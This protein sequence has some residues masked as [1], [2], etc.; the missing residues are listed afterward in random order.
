MFDPRS[1]EALVGRRPRL[2]LPRRAL[3]TAGDDRLVEQVRSGSNS[4]FEEIYDRHHR[5]IL[6]FCRHMLGSREEAEDAVQHTFIAA[7]QSLI[8]DDRQ[9]ALKAWL[10]TV[11]RNRCLSLLRAR[12]EHD[13]IDGAETVVP[14]TAGLSDEVEQREDLRTLLVD[15][16]RLPEDQRA[17]LVLAELEAH[18]HDEIAVILDVR[19]AKVK[20]LVFQAREGLMSRRLARE[21]DCHDIRE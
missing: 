3:C 9:I 6:A 18:S 11:A 13:N 8:A 19:P 21:A 12:R 7:Y 5:G 1:N 15:L 4:A 20:A 16:Q 2:S 14:A 17:A 10:Y